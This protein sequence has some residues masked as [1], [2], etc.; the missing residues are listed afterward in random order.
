MSF[1]P[2]VLVSAGQTREVV[3][4]L[5]KGEHYARKKIRESTK[6]TLLKEKDIQD[7]HGWGRGCP[8]GRGGE[9]DGEGH[10]ALVRLTPVGQLLHEPALHLHVALQL[11][12]LCLQGSHWK[13]EQEISVRD[14]SP[15]QCHSLQC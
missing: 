4:G 15:G 11:W 7:T 5:Q 12:Q 2:G 10:L 6:G 3:E 1:G 13:F 14:F 8:G 9:E